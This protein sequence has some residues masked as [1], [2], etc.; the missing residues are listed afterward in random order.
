MSRE[1][2]LKSC[3]FGG[4][5]KKQV[6]SEI[7][8][9]ENKIREKDEVIANLN[10][11]LAAFEKERSYI[12][13]TLLKAKSDG[14]KIVSDAQDEAKR[15]IDAAKEELGRLSALS[16]AEREK[17]KSLQKDA[18]RTLSEYNE[19]IKSIDLK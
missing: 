3:L 18:A 13:D 12:S 5:N 6:N 1:F 17:I 9:L 14:E 10:E 4:Y 11:K 15:R 2:L 19:H 8:I 7:G 16:E